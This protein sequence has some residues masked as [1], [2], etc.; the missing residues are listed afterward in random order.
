MALLSGKHVL[1]LV[2]TA[3]QSLGAIYFNSAIT[4]I[5]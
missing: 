3:P 4:I 5:F 2:E 1:Y